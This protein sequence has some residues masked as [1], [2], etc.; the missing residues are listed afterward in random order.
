[1]QLPLLFSATLFPMPVS[2]PGD[3]GRP[4]GGPLPPS[5]PRLREQLRRELNRH[6]SSNTISLLLLFFEE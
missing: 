3:G 4:D 2:D 1:M 5:G 6:L